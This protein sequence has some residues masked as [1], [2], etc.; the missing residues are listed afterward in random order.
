MSRLTFLTLR[1]Y[2]IYMFTD[3]YT[4]DE[5]LEYS[6]DYCEEYYNLFMERDSHCHYQIQRE[7]AY[8]Y[9]KYGV[10]LSARTDV[11]EFIKFFVYLDDFM[12][13][14]WNKNE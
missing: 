9:K 5:D 14:Y 13:A 1:S 11:D 8:L 2:P 10:E 6:D 12:L 3:G 7:G 4:F